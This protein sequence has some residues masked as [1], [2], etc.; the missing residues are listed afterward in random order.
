M[1]SPCRIERL[2]PRT[3][4]A[5]GTPSAVNAI[6]GAGEAAIRDIKVDAQGNR[7]VLGT[8]SG[9]ADFDPGP[10]TANLTSLGGLDLFV[11]KYSSQ[12]A[13][14]WVRRLGGKADE[15]AG[16]LAVGAG[17]DVFL[18]G[19][20]TGSVDFDPGPGAVTAAA[21]GKTDA[22]A[23]RLSARGKFC[24]A[25]AVGGTGYDVALDLEL[26]TGGSVYLAGTFRNSV[27]FRQGKLV[28]RRDS[29]GARDGLLTR[30]DA[31]T[32]IERRTE[33]L[34]GVND[35]MVRALHLSA[36]GSTIY[37]G[38]SFAGTTTFG[39]STPQQLTSQ[40]VTDGFLAAYD[41]GT[42]EVD[43]LKDYGAP[44]A[45]LAVND[46]AH[47][48]G[49]ILL[50][51]TFAGAAFGRTTVNGLDDIFVASLPQYATNSGAFCFIG[52]DGVDAAPRLDVRPD[53]S[54]DL[55]ATVAGTPAFFFAAN[56]LSGS[57]VG[58]GGNGDIFLAHIK[59]SRTGAGAVVVGGPGA[60]TA[61]AVVYD[62]VTAR[63]LAG[64]TFSGAVDFDYERRTK[65]ILTSVDTID[66]FLAEYTF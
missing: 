18:S 1:N 42:F 20:F 26:S 56:S 60:D 37:V 50:A 29:A 48:N 27:D 35:E 52:S 8:F 57:F 21:A 5:S 22:F 30:L 64:G 49:E 59:G 4:L 51:G 3:L 66:A 23:W 36:D 40:G 34:R 25:Y 6:G 58:A 2:E 63:L 43:D 9:T 11:A 39:F 19:G 38:G 44:G 46:I 14:V 31:A 41:S 61:A 33:Q 24:W 10:H 16:G 47:V 13:L 15:I 17:G 7:Y 53:E 45:T 12:N 55:A 28:D 54:I 62:P 32:G 65:L